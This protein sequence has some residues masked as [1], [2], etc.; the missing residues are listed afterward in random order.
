MTIQAIAAKSA[1]VGAASYG[2]MTAIGPR[3]EVGI[4][5]TFYSLPLVAA[6]VGAASSMIGDVSHM[7]IFPHIG[8]D[9]KYGQA[10]TAAVSAAA[11][12]GAFY[13]LTMATNTALPE[14]IGIATLAGTAVLSNA[15]GD[16]LYSTVLQPMLV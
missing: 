14:R 3:I 9:G 11:N 12:V 4:A 5:G 2:V 7:Y 15:L 6:G 16:Y 13:A 8:L 1:A 10:E